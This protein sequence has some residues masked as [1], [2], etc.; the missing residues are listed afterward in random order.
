ML[1]SP[2]ML[3]VNLVIKIITLIITGPCGIILNSSIV[4]VHLRHWKKGVSLGDCDQIIL[5]KGFTN[6]LLQC[7]LTF[8]GTINGFQ[9]YEHFDN[10]YFLV[11]YIVFFL[12]SF[13]FWLTAWLGICY[14]LRLVNI[15]HQFFFVLKQRVSS[16]IIQL[17]FGTAVILGMIIF[18]GFWTFDIKAKQNTSIPLSIDYFIFKG[19]SKCLS[20]NAAIGFCLP[21]LLNSLC[22]GLSLTSLLR[23]V[24]RVK[25]NNSQSWSGKMKTHAR[26]CVT[27]FLLMALNLFFFATVIIF[28]I[29]QFSSGTLLDTFFWTIIMACPS[30]QAIILFF[31]NSK[32]R[33]GSLKT[34]F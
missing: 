16:G 10:N 13:W 6:V 4:A 2:R 34:C 7:F 17:L 28:A 1:Q 23:H 18:P 27:I 26:A 3:L 21:T 11:A 20:F 8:S 15:S 25:K 29:L 31:G 32:L 9:L 19:D 12:S 14:C 33:S 30:G 22:I 5:I 24:Q